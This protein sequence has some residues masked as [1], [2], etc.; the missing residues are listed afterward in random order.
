MANKITDVEENMLTQELKESFKRECMLREELTRVNN[1]L[2]AENKK[3][4]QER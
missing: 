4:F 3:H 2:N 1:L